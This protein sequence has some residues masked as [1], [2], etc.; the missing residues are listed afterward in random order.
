V[1]RKPAFSRTRT[2]ALRF[3]TL[4]SACIPVALAETADRTKPTNIEANRM[5]AD[6][7]QRLTIW[8]GNVILSRG[9][10]RIQADR[11]VVRQDAE[12]FDTA[13]ATGKPVRFRQKSNP[14]GDCEGRW[15]DGEAMRVEVNNREERVQLFERARVT[16]DEDEI[17]GEAIVVDQRTDSFSVSGTAAPNAPGGRVSAVLQPKAT[18]AEAGAP[19]CPPSRPPPAGR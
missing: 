6:D 1:K 17:R 9:T 19:A 18:P 13:T 4:F 16:R 8:E 3:A 12:G 15:L 11:I 5:L 14:K 7:V 10:L 2:L